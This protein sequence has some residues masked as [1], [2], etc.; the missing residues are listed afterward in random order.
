MNNNAGICWKTRD[1]TTS[2][3]LPLAAPPQ[4]CQ[5][6][7][8]GGKGQGRELKLTRALLGFDKRNEVSDRVLHVLKHVVKEVSV[9]V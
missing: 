4:L 9:S 1:R 2:R 6:P 3:H 5:P 8:G 7:T